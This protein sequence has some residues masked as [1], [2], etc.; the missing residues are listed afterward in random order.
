MTADAT[1]CKTD[2]KHTFQFAR[3]VKVGGPIRYKCPTCHK[4]F[5]G[6]V[7]SSDGS[8]VTVNIPTH[9]AGDPWHQKGLFKG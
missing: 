9:I 8:K 4:S 2:G 5:L 3:K 6:K 7:V 1:L